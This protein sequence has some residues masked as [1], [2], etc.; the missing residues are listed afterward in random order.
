[1]IRGRYLLSTDDTTDVF[2]IRE[3][4]FV[5]E[6]GFDVATER[7][8]YDSMA[9]YALIY[10]EEEQPVGTGRLYVDDEG[11][12]T[13]GR[14]CVL[15]LAR[16]GQIGDL[17]ARMLLARAI[18]L[19]AHAIYADALIDTVDFFTRYGLRPISD[20]KTRQGAAYRTLCA[21]RDEIDLDGS[22][23]KQSGACNH[24]ASDCANCSKEE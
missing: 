5:D 14:V 4:V 1:M 3:Q 6:I 20:V 7:D 24:C 23:K 21:Q 2:H 13:L 16:G 10:D 17:I 15:K 9:V 11:R 8:E 12:F 22:C 19:N 18:D